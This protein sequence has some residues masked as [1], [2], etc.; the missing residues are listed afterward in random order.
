M[1]INTILLQG[2]ALKKISVTEDLSILEILNIIEQEGHR[3]ALVQNQKKE[4]QGIITD[5]DIRRGIVKHKTLDFNAT[6]II[7]YAPIT[8]NYSSALSDQISAIEKNNIQHLP[9]LDSKGQLVGLRVSSSGFVDHSNTIVIMAGGLGTRLHPLTL[10]TPK[11]MLKIGDT[12]ILE[13]IIERFKSQ[14]F[15]DFVI[16][17]N[18]LYEMITGYFGDGSSRDINIKYIHETKT[19]GTIGALSELL[20]MDGIKYPILLTNGDIICTTK[21]NNI[22]DFHNTNNFDATICAKDYS[23]TVPYGVIDENNS[24][25]IKIEEKPKISFNI[26]SGIYSFT[27]KALELIP[28]DTVF[29]ATSLIEILLDSDMTVGVHKIQDLWID[30]GSKEDLKKFQ[31]FI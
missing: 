12:P 29:D 22:L 17:V 15:K 23:I 28:K 30:I 10:D 1:I 4:F 27:R 3:I 24:E 31:D 2:D 21:Y 7:N 8:E 6:E 26:N 14:G 16:S 5:F 19:R 9:L 11:P 13:S 20:S 18:Y 25:L